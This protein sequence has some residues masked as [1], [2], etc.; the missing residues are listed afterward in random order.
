MHR[1]ILFTAFFIFL[2][3]P[4]VAF[5]Q[6]FSDGLVAVENGNY[7]QAIRIFRVAAEKGDKHAQHCLG[8]LLHKGV[9]VKQNHEEAFK[10]LQLAAKQGLSQANFDLGILVYQKKG[11]PENYQDKY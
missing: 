4:A 3:T 8:V 2:S 1:V 10:W 11:M 6:D 7:E 5:D 9:G